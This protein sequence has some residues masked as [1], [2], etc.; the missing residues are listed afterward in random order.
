MKEKMLR[1]AREKVRVTHKGKPIRLTADLS[2]ETLQARREW[3][4]IFNIL[5][6][7]NFQPRISYP[8]KLSFISEG[9]IKFFANKQ[10]LRDYITTRPALQ[11]LLKEALHMDGNNQYQPFQKHTKSNALSPSQTYQE[12]SYLVQKATIFQKPQLAI[13]AVLLIC[14]GADFQEQPDPM[15]AC[16]T[17]VHKLAATLCQDKTT[18]YCALGSG[19]FFCCSQE[20]KE[21]EDQRSEDHNQGVSKVFS[22]SLAFSTF[23]MMHLFVNL[24][25]YLTQFRFVELPEYIGTW[26]NLETITLSKLTQE[27]KAKHRMFSL[28]VPESSSLLLKTLKAMS[29]NDIGTGKDLITKMPKAV[30]IKAKIDKWDRIKE[31]LYSKGNYQKI[32]TIA[33]RKLSESA[34]CDTDAKASSDFSELELP[35]L[36]SKLIP[37]SKIMQEQQKV[38]P[39]TV[40]TKKAAS[41]GKEQIHVTFETRGWSLKLSPRLEWSGVISAHC[42]LHLPGSS[43]SPASASRV[44]GITSICHHTQ[45]IFWI[46]GTSD[47]PVSA[48]QVARITGLHLQATPKS[49]VR[50]N[51]TMLPRLEYSGMVSVHCSLHLLGSSDLPASASWVAGITGMCH[52]AQLIFVF[53]VEME[54]HHLCQA[55]LE[56]LTSGDPPASASQSAGITVPFIKAEWRKRSARGLGDP[57]LGSLLSVT[58]PY[59]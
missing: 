52:H 39:R 40:V 20:E 24:F 16:V 5:K 55:G 10:V 13:S 2:A 3:G 58:E 26:M 49:F 28:I 11:E 38:P 31:L 42:N 33:E 14:S 15:N 7:N 25:A 8:A 41:I 45:L 46:F 4:P 18:P 1:A 35:S 27:Q 37:Q 54:F 56:F 36:A 6:E 22:L 34:G 50:W 47:S 29:S 59:K 32:S 48:P 53:L 23:A 43:N 57:P 17:G 44:A 12:G 51:L 9:K 21:E 19:S 30:A